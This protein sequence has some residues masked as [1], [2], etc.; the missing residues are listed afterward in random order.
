MGE[1]ITTDA[2][3]YKRQDSDKPNIEDQHKKYM[4][5]QDMTLNLFMI[6]QEDITIL[7][8]YV[9]KFYKLQIVETGKTRQ[10]YYDE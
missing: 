7:K 3:H 6:M 4:T 10:R 2:D 9:E 8:A 1:D 5:T